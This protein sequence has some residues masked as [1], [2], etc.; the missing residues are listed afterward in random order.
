[1]FDQ[2]IL[3]RQ[4]RGGW[5]ALPALL[6]APSAMARIITGSVGAVLILMPGELALLHDNVAH[7]L[8]SAAILDGVKGSLGLVFFLRRRFG[9]TQGDPQ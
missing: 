8:D 6:K 2:F 3:S 5:P 4:R 7:A 9:G 1:M